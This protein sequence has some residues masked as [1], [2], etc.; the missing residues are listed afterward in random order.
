[1]ALISYEE[2]TNNVLQGDKGFPRILCG[3]SLEAVM[4]L[5]LL[6]CVVTVGGL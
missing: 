6:R 1:M 4:D 2:P 5:T 3:R